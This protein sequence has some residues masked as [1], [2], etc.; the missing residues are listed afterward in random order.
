MAVSL[1][2]YQCIRKTDAEYQ[3][4][5]H[6]R[7]FAFPASTTCTNFNFTVTH[8][9]MCNLS[10][11]KKSLRKSLRKSLK[12]SLKMS[13]K[14]SLKKSLKWKKITIFAWHLGATVFP[15]K[16]SKYANYRIIVFLIWRHIRPSTHAQLNSVAGQNAGILTY[17][18]GALKFED[19]T[20]SKKK[21]PPDY[22]TKEALLFQRKKNWC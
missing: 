15:T 21:L 20:I 4:N 9:T 8:A 19:L 6:D 1:V 10:P 5:H 7:L 14:K 17:F 22:S 12:K 2:I 18:D 3:Q 13:L 11:L 16:T